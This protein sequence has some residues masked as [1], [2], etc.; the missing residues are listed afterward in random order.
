VQKL[1][2]RY[3]ISCD[4]LWEFTEISWCEYRSI[5][6]SEEVT[7]GKSPADFLEITDIIIL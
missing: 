6:Y 7:S 4:I 1:L 2:C 3:F 5:F